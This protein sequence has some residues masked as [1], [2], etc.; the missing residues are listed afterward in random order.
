MTRPQGTRD[1]EWARLLEAACPPAVPRPG[2]EDR[3]L[4]RIRQQRHGSAAR[5]SRGR[6]G[7]PGWAAA[8]VACAFLLGVALASWTRTSRAPSAHIELGMP[9]AELV[10]QPAMA[11]PA[12]PEP[13][14]A[15]RVAATTADEL[16]E[17]SR[18]ARVLARAGTS[19]E[20]SE[21]SDVVECR[22]G[23]G[24]VL[25]HVPERS[26]GKF[27]VVTPTQ[28]VEVSGTVFGVS[29]S[30]AGETKVS[31]WE[32][33]VEVHGV[34]GSASLSAGESWPRGAAPL[35]ADRADMARLS[36]SARV[37][38][39][40]H[41]VSSAASSSGSPRRS[42]GAPAVDDSYAR[43]RELEVAGDR[44]GAAA[45]YERVAGG[46]GATAEAAAFA[47][48][49]LY[50]G[51]AEHAAVRRVLSSH[52]ARHPAGQ[53]A[54]AAD[55]LWLRTL[56][57]EGD[58]TGIER[59]AERFLRNHPGDPRASQFRA[60]RALD[61]ARRGRCVEARVD[62]AEVEAGVRQRIDVLCAAASSTP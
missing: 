16:L 21:G 5:R 9:P 40:P 29:A 17:L 26:H 2:A 35:R 55:V 32:G 13:V 6:A 58:S 18:G 54:R 50:S 43:A 51:L 57:A 60:A 31:V 24:E 1:P 8:A 11:A 34:A 27:I 47:A 59:E 25:V 53:F 14:E 38:E 49:R 46:D 56:V 19:I 41:P 23:V 22:L 33:R 44:A 61:R 39:L 36:A 4:E 15:R 12:P 37:G 10:D 42:A 3:V 20:L 28:R 7:A 45:L 62:G 30:A 52:R 48:A